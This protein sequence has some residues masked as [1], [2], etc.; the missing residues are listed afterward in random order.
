M[1]I[2]EVNSILH[3]DHIVS[4]HANRMRAFFVFTNIFQKRLAMMYFFYIIEYVLILYDNQ[5]LMKN[6]NANDLNKKKL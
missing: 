3:T 5:E 6:I 1:E 4:S 2:E